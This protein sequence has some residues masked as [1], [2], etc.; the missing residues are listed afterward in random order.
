MVKGWN[1]RLIRPIDS[2][3]VAVNKAWAQALKDLEGWM[4]RDLINALVN[5]GFGIQGIKETSFYGFI[6]SPEG[7][8][9]LGIE[10]SD[11]PKL[12]EAYRRTFKV[13]KTNTMLVFKFG[14]T[15]RLKLATPHPYA[16]NGHL[17]VQSWLEFIVDGVQAKSGFVP[18][19]KLPKAAQKNIRVKSAPG[20]LMLPQGKAG[21]TG[22]W[23]FPAQF[24]KYEVKWFQS[25]VAKIEKAIQE[26]M[27]RFLTKRLS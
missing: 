13:S 11:P 24:Q 25:N 23:R 14:D 9:Q 18:R 12:L 6:S 4:E 8:S 16:N 21:S 22:A 3:K 7:L 2:I 5:G 27:A 1:L 20:G 10:K 17:H 19:A 15:A 26:A